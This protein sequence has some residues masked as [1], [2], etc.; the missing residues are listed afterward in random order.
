MDNL[1][2]IKEYQKEI[3]LLSNAISLL[4][5]DQQTYMPK[6]AFKNRSEQLALLSKLVHEKLISKELSKAIEEINLDSLNETDKI[7][8]ERL[9]HDISMSKKLPTKFVEELSRASSLGFSAWEKA[10]KNND[11]NSFKPYLEK[12]VELRRKESE[13]LGLP[14]HPYNSLLDKFE[15]GMTIEKIEPIFEKL[16]EGLLELLTKIKNSKKYNEEKKSLIKGKD[17]SHEKQIELA[18]S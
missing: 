16:K 12:M 14:G 8:V 10:K 13:Y 4:S 6:D 9:N 2:L 15:E 17:F 3:S 1:N 11:F 7:M 18:A 5:W